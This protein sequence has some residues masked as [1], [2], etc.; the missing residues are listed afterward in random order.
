MNYSN[1]QGTRSPTETRRSKKNL[2]GIF[3]PNPEP[4][5]VFRIGLIRLSNFGK[6]FILKKELYKSV[7]KKSRINLYISYIIF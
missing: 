7:Y 2:I 4:Q 5:P 1:I 6:I 3:F